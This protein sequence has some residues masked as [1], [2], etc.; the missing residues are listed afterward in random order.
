MTWSA[1]AVSCA[2]HYAQILQISSPCFM[3][4]MDLFVQV[5]WLVLCACVCVRASVGTIPAQMEE[6]LQ[7]RLLSSVIRQ[8]PFLLSDS[9]LGEIINFSAI[10]ISKMFYGSE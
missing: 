3:P 10:L 4:R 1:Q 6:S 5:T 2:S 9:T 7:G 8:D